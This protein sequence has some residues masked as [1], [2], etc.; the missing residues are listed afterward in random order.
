[1]VEARR[2][3]SFFRIIVERDRKDNF[4]I[5]QLGSTRPIVRVFIRYVY[6]LNDPNP[7]IF[8]GEKDTNSKFI[9]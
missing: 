1:M 8:L 5:P 9:L 4:Q 2:S 6:S 7:V 3:I